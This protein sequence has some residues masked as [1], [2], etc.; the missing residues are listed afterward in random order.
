MLYYWKLI[1]WMEILGLAVWLTGMGILVLSAPLAPNFHW[2][3]LLWGCIPLL[4]LAG[5]RLWFK[6]SFLRNTS[7]VR[8]R[9]TVEHESL[10]GCYLLMEKI[11]YLGS[12]FVFLAVSCWPYLIVLRA[13]GK[14]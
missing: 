10:Y 8:S 14:Y 4:A 9:S 3:D 1:K 2:S 5:S 11:V 6:P 12:V 7:R 13:F